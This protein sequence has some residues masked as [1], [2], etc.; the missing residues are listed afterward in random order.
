MS[1]YTIQMKKNTDGE[2]DNLYPLTTAINVSLEDG[3][4]I[5][6]T[7]KRIDGKIDESVI[8]IDGKISETENELSLLDRHVPKN[9]FDSSDF[10]TLQEAVYASENGVLHVKKGTYTINTPIKIKSNT[11]I[12]AY[13]SIFKRNANINNLFINDSDGTRGVYEANK[14][15]EILGA[16]FDGSG[17][18]FSYKCTLVAFGHVENVKIIDCTFR[19]LIDWHM[20]ELNSVRNCLVENCKFEDYGNSTIG[21]EMV[22]ID[23]AK[24]IDQFPWFPPYDNTC[25]D[26]ITIQNCKFLN[27][28]R[29]IGTHSDTIGF[30]HTRITIQY[31]E[32]R[33]M[34]A[35]TISGLNWAFTKI[36]SNHMYNVQKGILYRV[37][38]KDLFNH[39]ITDNY[40]SG[41]EDDENSRGIQITGVENGFAINAGSITGNRIKRFGSHSIGVDFSE[42]WTI[43]N[44]DVSRSGKT[45]IIIFG[46][47][48]CTI[49]DNIVIES[50]LSLGTNYYDIHLLNNSSKSVVH[51]NVVNTLKLNSDVFE[52]IVF[53]NMVKG[54]LSVDSVKSKA[55]NNMINTVFT[56]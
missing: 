2:W 42:F 34:R 39:S 53:G 55:F 14:N 38:A 17:T 4:T 8:R 23:I 7:V 11:K 52:V 19:N 12:V 43:T 16:V 35:E 44:N 32:F 49:T 36:H 56:P 10:A 31:N 20:L 50:N 27:G 47:S 28:V 5:E 51:G 1:D 9:H 25:C 30:E 22:Q 15:I 37:T 24:G 46:S 40:I 18:D 21:T 33:N 3:Q 41:K 26:N 6:E 29:G 45:G 48:N 54:S 13:G